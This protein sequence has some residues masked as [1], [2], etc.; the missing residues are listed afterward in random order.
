MEA[1]VPDKES[2]RGLVCLHCDVL[3]LN[4]YFASILAIAIVDAFFSGYYSHQLIL[5]E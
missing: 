3:T 1:V 5:S 2:E 4:F